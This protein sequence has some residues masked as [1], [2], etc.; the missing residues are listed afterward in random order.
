MQLPLRRRAAGAM[1]R[2]VRDG[3]QARHRADLV[4]AASA[5]GPD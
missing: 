2:A 4:S 5:S 3:G 1:G